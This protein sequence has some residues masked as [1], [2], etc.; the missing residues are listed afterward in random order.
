[1]EGDVIIEEILDEPI[2]GSEAAHTNIAYHALKLHLST[3]D[4]KVLNSL[5]RSSRCSSSV[6]RKRVTGP[7]SRIGKYGP[8]FYLPLFA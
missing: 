7:C 2:P 1:M 3:L 5:P 8:E 6:L 4:C